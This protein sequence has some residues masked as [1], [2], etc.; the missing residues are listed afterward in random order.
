MPDSSSPPLQYHVFDPERQEIRVITIEP[1]VRRYWLHALLFLA[2]IFST[3]CIGARLQFNFN[4]SLPA[5]SADADYWPWRW[6]LADWRRLLLGIPFSAT[7]LGILT[8]HEFGHYFFCVRRRVYATLPFFVPAPTLIGTLGAF[9]RIKSPIR[10]RGDLFDIGIAGP[11]AGFIVGLPLLVLGLLLSQPLTGAAAQSDISFGLP[12]IFSA[13]HWLCAALGSTNIAAMRLDAVN[14]S[15]VAIAAW[16]GMFATAL[17]LL[18]GGQLDGGHIIFAVRP[19]LHRRISMVSIL[20]LLVLSW[21]CWAGWLLWAV[22]LR[23][24]GSRH[25]DV[26]H[27]PA[28]D[29]KRLWL[30]ALALLML[31]VTF[32]P[33]PIKERDDRTGRQ[34]NGSLQ[35][36]LSDYR[37]SHSQPSPSQ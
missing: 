31:I 19:S 2:T 36:I 20:V 13:A 34:V 14:L 30:A 23:F 9:I 12:L 17:N 8:A 18:P 16:V 5:I 28:L 4:H 11:I 37:S 7:L 24:T 35:N 10:S 15:P 29:R 25:P 22:V 33:S 26:P 32:A 3:L 6:V 27:E 1:P 21:Y